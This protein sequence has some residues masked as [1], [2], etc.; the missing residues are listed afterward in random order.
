MDAIPITTLKVERCPRLSAEDFI[1]LLDLNHK[2]FS[3]P[4]MVV[5]DVRS[6]NK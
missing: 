5:V 2:R 3:R 6:A 1:E 4:K